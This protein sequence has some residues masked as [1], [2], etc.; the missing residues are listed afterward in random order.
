M[1]SVV[2]TAA[3]GED[4]ASAAFCP[5][6]SN[7]GGLGSVMFSPPSQY[8]TDKN[9]GRTPPPI[10]QSPDDG[11]RLQRLEDVR[12]GECLNSNKLSQALRSV[13]PDHAFHSAWVVN[14]VLGAMAWNRH[15]AIPSIHH[16][17]SSLGVAAGL[18]LQLPSQINFAP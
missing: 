10:R 2:F 1:S 16:C 7:Y 3:S 8:A 9:I 12:H 17:S 5:R 11:G 14:D 6:S 13:Q 18:D 15:Q 4:R